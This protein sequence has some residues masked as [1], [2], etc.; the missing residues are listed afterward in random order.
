MF[1]GLRAATCLVAVDRVLLADNG[2][3][4]QEFDLIEYGC[5][6]GRRRELTR[7]RIVGD[8]GTVPMEVVR[9]DDLIDGLNDMLRRR[10]GCGCY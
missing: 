10:P 5:V 8:P 9:L 2:W 7:R 4:A 1:D 6:D 3:R